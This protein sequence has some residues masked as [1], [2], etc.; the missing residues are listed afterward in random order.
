MLDDRLVLRIQVYLLV[1]VNVVAQ[2]V[3]LL[4]VFR[5]RDAHAVPAR[6]A[7]VDRGVVVCGIVRIALLV[8]RS[9]A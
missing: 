2:D 3:V 5:G 8:Y 6:D 4:V 7:V 1:H 9:S